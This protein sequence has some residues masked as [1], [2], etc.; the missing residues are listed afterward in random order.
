MLK[1]RLLQVDLIMLSMVCIIII[2]G[3]IE[4]G[5]CHLC[6]AVLPRNAIQLVVRRDDVQTFFVFANG[7]EKAIK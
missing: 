4:K 7:G 6:Q 1:E 2:I 3:W 5:Q